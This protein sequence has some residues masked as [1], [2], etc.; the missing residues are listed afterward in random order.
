MLIGS[1]GMSIKFVQW[2]MNEIDLKMM[3]SKNFENLLMI[4][5]KKL[6]FSP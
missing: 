1:N 6:I 5:C 2:V 4:D 3:H